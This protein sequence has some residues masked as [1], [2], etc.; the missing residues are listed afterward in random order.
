MLKKLLRYDFRDLLRLMLPATIAVL[1]CGALGGGALR[2]LTAANDRVFFLNTVAVAV[3][4]VCSIGMIVYACLPTIW[5]VC[6]YYQSLF[7]DEGFLTFTLPAPVSSILTSKIISG[8]TVILAGGLISYLSFSLYFLVGLGN[9]DE[10]FVALHDL[11]RGLSHT[12]VDFGKPVE[13]VTLTVVSIL[14]GQ[15]LS[16]NTVLLS[17]TLSG[18]KA[19]KHKVLVGI[20]IYVGISSAVGTV[21]SIA[22]AAFDFA[23]EIT[24]SVTVSFLLLY[25]A[26]SLGLGVALY[27][28]NRRMLNRQLDL[29]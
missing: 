12:L 11:L 18:L 21:Q 2:F 3:V 5:V 25:I 7:T 8:F 29:T 10:L 28:V 6:R 13:I 22:S 9:Y 1:C 17:F 4:V 15:F 16:L 19:N 14:A 20:L 24:A 23:G 26:L 27:L